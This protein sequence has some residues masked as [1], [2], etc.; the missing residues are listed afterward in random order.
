MGRGGGGGES[1]ER[2]NELRS[3]ADDIN[4]AS[5]LVSFIDLLTHHKLRPW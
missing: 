4:E 2:T 3:P 1:S 5:Y